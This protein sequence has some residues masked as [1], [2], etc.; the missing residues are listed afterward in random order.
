MRYTAGFSVLSLS[1][2][3]TPSYPPSPSTAHSYSS[4][5][6]ETCFTHCVT[7]FTR[8][9][10]DDKEKR[11]INQCAHRFMQSY[12]RVGMRFGTCHPPCIMTLL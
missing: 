3:P 6:T 7:T 12:E 9:Y 4:K 1:L 10:L 5:L 2:S 11:C 8:K